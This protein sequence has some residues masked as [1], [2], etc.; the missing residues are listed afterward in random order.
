MGASK[1]NNLR[2]ISQIILIVVTI[3][4]LAA[5]ALLFFASSFI[6]KFADGTNGTRVLSSLGIETKLHIA[7]IY[8]LGAAIIAGTW[9]NFLK[10]S[11]GFKNIITITLIIISQGSLILGIAFANAEVYP[12]SSTSPA[13]TDAKLAYAII[14]STLLFVAFLILLIV[15]AKY[16]KSKTLKCLALVIVL[17]AAQIASACILWG[18]LPHATGSK[19]PALLF[20]VLNLTICASVIA[21]F[22]LFNTVIKQGSKNKDGSLYKSGSVIGK[23]CLPLFVVCY[24]IT[25]ITGAVP[26]FMLALASATPPSY[27]GDIS[28]WAH[29]ISGICLAGVIAGEALAASSDIFHKK[30]TNKV[31]V[32]NTKQTTDTK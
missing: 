17:A 20:G 14:T 31:G 30:Q 11:L 32:Q 9:A 23:I 3:V 21:F 13:D 4:S 15:S 5:S 27:I 7:C 24:T 25:A 29:L 12:I 26:F 8:L 22:S 18:I 19:I 28:D 10:S 1:Q 16:F 6:E 2:N